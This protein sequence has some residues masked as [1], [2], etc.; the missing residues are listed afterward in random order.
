[1]SVC[2][3]PL[4]VPSIHS[5]RLIETALRRVAQ[6]FETNVDEVKKWPQGNTRRNHHDDI[7]VVV[8]FF[9]E[10]EKG[11]EEGIE[12]SEEEAVA[13]GGGKPVIIDKSVK[14]EEL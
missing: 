13:V 9:E 5:Y 2:C 3:P 7:T 8:L 4:V 10:E 11:G 12:C 1:M 6:Q 14:K